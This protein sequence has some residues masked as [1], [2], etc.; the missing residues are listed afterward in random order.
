MSQ[1]TRGP[2]TDEVEVEAYRLH[3]LPELRESLNSEKV[4]R[5]AARQCL[6]LLAEGRDPR[7]TCISLLA[8]LTS[9]EASPTSGER[10]RIGA[11]A[12]ICISL[13]HF[14]QLVANPETVYFEPS[15]PGGTL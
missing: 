1:E 5:S 14:P 13:A 10:F 15:R 9:P 6:R 8:R 11:V 12:A 2:L 4:N 3:E 7:E